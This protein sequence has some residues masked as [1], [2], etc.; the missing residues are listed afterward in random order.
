M[1]DVILAGFWLIVSS[2][3]VALGVG[4][5]GLPTIIA[6]IRK[7]P[8]IA[9][10]ATVNLVLGGLVVPWWIALAMALWA[11]DRRGDVTVVQTT[12]V[13][14]APHAVLHPVV[15]ADS[16]R[17][18]LSA[19]PAAHPAQPPTLSSSH[20]GERDLRPYPQQQ[21]FGPISPYGEA[22]SASQGPA[23]DQRK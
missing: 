20:V 18:A 15:Q 5:Y 11:T 6:I 2:L 10:I 3:G 14:P 23:A 1:S 12:N 16:Y 21:R 19:P 17:P 4:L 22:P 9:L 13:P 7:S 8:N